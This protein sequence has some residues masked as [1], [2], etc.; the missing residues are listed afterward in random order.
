MAAGVVIGARDPV[1]SQ[2][3]NNF[4]L[5]DCSYKKFPRLRDILQP[6]D[7]NPVSI[8]DRFEFSLVL[9]RVVVPGG[10]QALLY[11]V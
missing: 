5:A 11:F 3:Y 8:P 9:I 6:T 4:L 1:T 10:R 2:G 7:A